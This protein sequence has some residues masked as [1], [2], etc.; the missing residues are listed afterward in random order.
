MSSTIESLLFLISSIALVLLG[1]TAIDRLRSLRLF[2]PSTQR[3][4]DLLAALEDLLLPL[5]SFPSEL[6]R[7]WAP[8]VPKHD[9][10]LTLSPVTTIVSFDGTK[11]CDAPQHEAEHQQQESSTAVVNEASVTSQ[12]FEKALRELV[13]PEGKS[14]PD[15][16]KLVELVANTIKGRT[17]AEDKLRLETEN[18]RRREEDRRNTW[19]DKEAEFDR[20][21]PGNN[22]LLDQMEVLKD[23][24]S[25]LDQKLQHKLDEYNTRLKNL[26][27]AKEAAEERARTAET[28]TGDRIN[29]VKKRYEKEKSDAEFKNQQDQNSRLC[30]QR[31]VLD[32]R[33]RSH[34]RQAEEQHQ[35]AMI[36][37]DKTIDRLQTKI[38]QMTTEAIVAEE[39]AAERAASDKERQKNRLEVQL[40]EKD[41]KI[42]TLGQQL[43]KS[44]LEISALRQW[45]S[46]AKGAE[47]LNERLLERLR[48]EKATLREANQHNV[49]DLKLENHGHLR[50]IK[51]N[52]VSIRTLQGRIASLE[53]GEELSNLKAQLKESR[54]LQSTIEARHKTII[55]EATKASE[56]KDALR[57]QLEE[58]ARIANTGLE[59]EAR[60]LAKQKDELSRKLKTALNENQVSRTN[61]QRLEEEKQRAATDHEKAIKEREEEI[62]RLRQVVQDTKNE[63]D[64]KTNEAEQ[65]ARKLERDHEEEKRKAVEEAVRKVTDDAKDQAR[66]LE[67]DHEEE[68]K[69]AVEDAV[70][71]VR[72]EAKDQAR[73]HER[74]KQVAVEK[75]AK[76]AAE[77]ATKEA[78]E[79]AAKEAAENA[80]KEAAENVSQ[81]LQ[82]QLEDEKQELPTNPALE[83]PITPNP[84]GRQI[85]KPRVPQRPTQSGPAK[86]NLQHPTILT[87]SADPVASVTPAKSRDQVMTDVTPKAVTEK[88]PTPSRS[89]QSRSATANLQ[90]P[91]RMSFADL[92]ASVSSSKSDQSMTDAT[93]TTVPE[94]RPTRSDPAKTK[95]QG[96]IS[97]PPADVLGQSPLPGLQSEVSDPAKTNLQSPIP[98]PSADLLAQS[99]LPGLQN[100]VEVPAAPIA[101]AQSPLPGLQSEVEASTNPYPRLKLKPRGKLGKQ[102]VNPQQ[103]SS[104]SPSQQDARSDM[105]SK[106]TAEMTER[107]TSMLR[108]GDD[109]EFVEEIIR[110][111]YDVQVVDTEGWDVWLRKLQS[112]CEAEKKGKTEQP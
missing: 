73:E 69:K 89:T 59:E 31:M 57:K 44:N 30:R 54:K 27:D 104:S 66:K 86:T 11:P 40:K 21:N 7:L 110:E 64:A 70:G 56:A 26:D 17:E 12:A 8:A 92:L 94:K 47:L 19:K 13:D 103:G 2:D 90:T 67:R 51:T 45:E 4:R 74:D 39:V 35:T 98:A 1:I 33:N 88:G 55:D 58:A 61:V 111:M 6:L 3:V 102:V 68:K 97:T 71:K 5:G 15:L 28:E 42:D 16:Q 96:P 43:G 100:E 95:T 109:V 49:D 77:K 63:L 101:K 112:E 81:T 78:A 38:K 62:R 32:D 87:Q 52:E 106:W 36:C 83:T 20:T 23:Q 34:L 65:T 99:P 25:G 82:K 91:P 10:T 72:D 48:D 22:E 79:K 29:A 107:A 108:D 9:L 46:R 14:G 24:K 80:A 76:E 41:S 18:F 60:E 84:F 85:R 75:A 50:T 93:P 105:P 37:K 53:D